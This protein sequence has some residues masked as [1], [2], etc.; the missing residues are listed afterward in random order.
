M[1]KKR[2]LSQSRLH[3]EGE[4][5]RDGKT[6]RRS[7]FGVLPCALLL[8]LC[9][10]DGHE[11]MEERR[12]VM[13]CD[14]VETEHREIV[15]YDQEPT[16]KVGPVVDVIS[17]GSLLKE[18]LQNAQERTFGSADAV[19]H[20][21]RITERNDTDS[22][23]F[24]DLT[25]EQMDQIISFCSKTDHQS[26]ISKTF[27]GRLFE[28]KKHA[29]WMCAQKRP[30]DGLFQVLQRYLLGHDAIPDYLFII[31]DDTFLNMERLVPDLVQH[32]PSDLPFV[33]AGCNYEFLTEAGITFPYGG[34]GSYLSRKAIERLIQPFYCD[35]RDEHSNLACWRL[36]LNALGEK[37]FYTEGMSVND[38]MQSYSANLKLTDVEHWT[39]TGYCLHSDHALAY[40]LNFYHIAVPEGTVDRNTRPNDKV[41]RKNSY[42]GI[43]GESECHHERGNCTIDHRIC[44]YIKP[45]QMDELFAI[46]ARYPALYNSNESGRKIQ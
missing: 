17:V 36:N 23:C 13:D 5:A 3:V 45:K 10:L 14:H 43:I 8:S 35:S 28:P 39:D 26:Y 46:Q 7:L 11:L 29:G 42:V 41:R 24:T 2:Q 31:D 38:L 40:F 20:F 4:V 19:R 15:S 1:M 21:F 37:K 18:E 34:F 12:R 27:R 9:V 32:Y 25:T 6:F 16:K 22:T 33:V 30:L 44:H